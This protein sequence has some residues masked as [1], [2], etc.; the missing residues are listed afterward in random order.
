MHLRPYVLL[1]LFAAAC[2]AEP[3]PAPVAAPVEVRAPA[4]AAETLFDGATLAN[5]DG[6]PRFWRVENGCIVGESTT[7][8]PCNATTY[9]LWRGGALEDF[10]LELDFRLTGGNSGVQFRSEDRGGWQVAGFQADLEDGPNWSGCLYEQ[11]GAGVVATRGEEVLLDGNGARKERFGDA[12]KLLELVKPREWNRYRISARGERV[13]LSINGTLFTSVVDLRPER[14]LAGLLALQLHQG[15]PMKAE[16]RNFELRRLPKAD[17]R[18]VVAPAPK[19]AVASDGAHRISPNFQGTKP[20]W[21]WSSADSPDWDTIV[22]ARNFQLATPPVRTLLR[23]SAD[24]HVRVF[25]NGQLALTNDDWAQALEVDVSKLVKDGD[26]ELIALAWNEGGIAAA[27]FELVAER[28]GARPLRV[29]SDGSWTAQRLSVNTDRATWTPATLDRARFSPAHVVGGFGMAPWGS[30]AF[31]APAAVADERAL[32]AEDLVLLPGFRAE[33]LYSVPKAQQ[34]SWVSLCEDPAGRFYTSDQYGGLFRISVGA[35]AAETKVEPVP[36]ELGSAHGLCWAFDSLYAV[37]SESSGRDNGLYRVR[38]TDGDD[39]LDNVQLLRKFEGGGEH[40]PHAVVLSPDGTGLWIVGGNHTP[41][42]EPIDVYLRPKNWAEDI[43][44]PRIEDPNGHAVGIRAPGG[45]I[46]VTDSEAKRWTLFCA[47]FRNAYDI[48]F[49]TDGELFTFD[50]DMEWDIG[51]PWYQPTRIFHCVSGAD[52]GWRGGPGKMP[53]DYPDTW[54]SVVDIGMSSP[55]GVTFGTGA[56]FPQKYQRAMFA[57]DWAYGKVYAV[58]MEPKGSTYTGSFEEFA[59][60]R[61]FPV[62]DIVIGKDG[63]M[64]ITTGGR[65]TQSGLY[66]ITW[67]GAPEAVDSVAAG[68]SQ[69]AMPDFEL[70]HACEDAYAGSSGNDFESTEAAEV[71]SGYLSSGR[72]FTARAARL[73]LQNFDP[74]HWYDGAVIG[75]TQALIA[76]LNTHPQEYGG[77][78]VDALEASFQSPGEL[79]LVEKLR[80]TALAL[81]RAPQTKDALVARVR[82]LLEKLYP[83]GSAR[84]DRELLQVLV[85]LDSPRALVPALDV[86][87]SNAPQEERIWAAYC[88]RVAGAGWTPELRERQFRGLAS[89]LEV[90]KGGHSLR[91]YIEEIRRQSA[92]FLDDDT[93]ALVAP[94]LEAPKPVVAAAAAKVEPMKFVRNW[95]RDD[96]AGFVKEP[97]V[98]RNFERGRE[99]FTRARCAECHRMA[100]EGG[101]TGPDLTGAGSRFSRSDWL[102]NLL[103]PSKVISDQYQDTEVLTT[104]G[105][106]YV[107]RIERDD[108]TGITLR[109]LP[110]Q[111]DT[112]DLAREQIERRRLY[113][114]SRMPAGLL[115][116]LS[117][118]D[119]RD[120]AAYVLSGANA[121]SPEFSKP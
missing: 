22:L 52:Y 55:T 56:K 17:A 115:D 89:L 24:N 84:I 18:A 120:L 94:F 62:T 44:L 71:L 83:Y 77:A 54:P 21:I 74:K 66:R 101:G 26:N 110:P 10:E 8:N 51:T 31:A 85:A 50:S 42:P 15:P 114:Y 80:V 36:I 98:A 92:E 4:P 32:P 37:V 57:L 30:L 78:V 117:E 72:G 100:G 68:R 64:Y 113:P 53:P 6:D 81:C 116:V 33:L 38:D 59:S 109:R 9:L 39:V 40:G 46:V 96:L 35:T 67:A 28:D 90:A 27:W 69:Q 20:N 60:G 121:A 79:K 14:R 58:H 34:G 119:V 23:G 88:L 65:R 99:L 75:N 104:D 95:T 12:A 76:L 13:E 103:E 19:P 11:D 111:E 29:L 47:G 82:P 25:L 5:W 73:A 61:P 1:A 108:A 102:D 105:E 97:L 63:A 7:T 91:K 107:G 3:Q 49:N 86:L 106:L 48:A 87:E 2:Q 43:L 118:D 41:L 93:H 45:W 16:Y 70:R 112:I